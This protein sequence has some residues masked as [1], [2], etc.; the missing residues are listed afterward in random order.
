MRTSNQILDNI[1]VTKIIDAAL[2][3]KIDEIASK[4]LCIISSINFSGL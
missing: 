1:T 3:G 2:D 4:D